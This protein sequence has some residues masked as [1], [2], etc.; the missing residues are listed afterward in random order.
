MSFNRLAERRV[1]ED[2]LAASIHSTFKPEPLPNRDAIEWL[3]IQ[4]MMMAIKKE[5]KKRKYEQ[6]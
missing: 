3:T 1:Q 2:S 6:G 5:A 4:E